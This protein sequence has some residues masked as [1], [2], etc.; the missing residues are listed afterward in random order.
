MSA[1]PCLALLDLLKTVILHYILV[2]VFLVPP[3]CVH[4]D[5]RPDQTE[6]KRRPLTSFCF[7]RF[8]SF[9]FVPVCFPRGLE[10]AARHPALAS[11]YSVWEF[12]RIAA[13][14]ASPL[15]ASQSNSPA[16]HL[17]SPPVAA[18]PSP[19]AAHQSSSPAATKLSPPAAA[20]SSLPVDQQSTLSADHLSSL[21]AAAIP[22]PLAAPQSSSSGTHQSSLP[23][24]HLSSP[25][26]VAIP[27]PPATHQS[28]SQTAPKSSLQAA[29]C[30][31]P[32]A[33][34]PSSPPSAG[35]STPPSASLSQARR[36]PWLTQARR[37]P[38]SQVCG[39]PLTEAR[40][41]WLPL[42]GRSDVKSAGCTDVK[43][44]GCSY[45]QLQWFQF[46]VMPSKD[47]SFRALPCEGPLFLRITPE[48]S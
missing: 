6:S 5:R 43:P 24:V 22:S 15:D 30:S 19:P 13:S 47:L 7:V 10:V 1:L 39:P 18:N 26:A 4:R 11:C 23:A 32:P 31:K 48:G 27:S 28:S 36:H 16:I 37:L 3:C 2:C 42:V 12:G 29:V 9:L 44:A 21:P 25:P 20:H 40:R 33:A 14:A 38:L 34:A 41:L 8:C 17:S 46:P 45:L 35:I